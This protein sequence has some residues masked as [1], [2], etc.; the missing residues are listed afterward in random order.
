MGGNREDIQTQP[1]KR[2]REKGRGIHHEENS[3]GDSRRHHGNTVSRKTQINTKMQVSQG[4][5]LGGNQI[6]LED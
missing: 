3:R 2:E 1:G 4:F 5:W 6:S